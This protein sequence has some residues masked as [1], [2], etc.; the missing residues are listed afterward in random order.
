MFRGWLAVCLITVGCLLSGCVTK[1]SSD[2]EIAQLLK[3]LEA[4]NPDSANATPATT[5]RTLDAP[6][7]PAPS[8]SVVAVPVSASVKS[9]QWTF[10]TGLLKATEN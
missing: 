1:Q 2:Q 5:S 6:R 10:V 8:E 7:L 9:E 4:L 3:E